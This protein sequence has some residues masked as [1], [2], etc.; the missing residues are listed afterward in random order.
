[1]S[2][3]KIAA[4]QMGCQFADVPSNRREIRA[5]FREAANQGAQLVVFPE[6]IL[7]GYAFESAEEAWPHTEK[8]PGPTTE[9]LANDCREFNAWCVF[10]LLECGGDRFYNACALV[11]PE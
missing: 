9:S 5:R 4:V 3:W 1:M 2:T 6:C 10:G 8:L 11:G 7:S